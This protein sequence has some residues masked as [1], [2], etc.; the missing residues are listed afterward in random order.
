MKHSG[1]TT[2]AKPNCF[3][4]CFTRL[5]HDVDRENRF[6]L[7]WIAHFMQFL[8]DLSCVV[9]FVFAL[10]SLPSGWRSVALIV[11]G[12]LMH[13]IG[14]VE[15]IH[16]SFSDEVGSPILYTCYLTRFRYF[17]SGCCLPSLQFL[18]AL[19]GCLMHAIGCV[20]PPDWL[21]PDITTINYCLRIEQQTVG[22]L[23]RLDNMIP[24]I[25]NLIP[26]V[27]NAIPTSTGSSNEYFIAVYVWFV[28]SVFN[29]VFVSRT[30]TFTYSDL[31]IRKCE[32][33]Q[34]KQNQLERCS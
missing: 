31:V 22:L 29:V 15:A 34:E 33:R 5:R 3:V 11:I 13:V 4:V 17:V 19:S 27:W 1:E 6:R 2:V 23:I 9:L 8:F 12:C 28:C 26:Y 20:E 16:Y 14:C 32:K 10:Y 25:D 30:Y 24:F 21:C 18:V 7:G